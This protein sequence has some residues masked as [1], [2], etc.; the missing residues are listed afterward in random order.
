MFLRH[1]RHELLVPVLVLFLFGD[2]THVMNDGCFLLHHLVDRPNE[3]DEFQCVAPHFRVVAAVQ[4]LDIE[5]P[6]FLISLLRR[7][8]QLAVFLQRLIVFGQQGFDLRVGGNVL[9]HRLELVILYI[10]DL[11]P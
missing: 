2:R 1:E 4:P 8:V 10:R 11:G 5:Q 6:A 7:V 3:R 9:R